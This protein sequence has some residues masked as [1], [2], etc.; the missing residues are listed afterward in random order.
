[1][2][3]VAKFFGF[4]GFGFC[5]KLNLVWIQ[6]ALMLLFYVVRVVIMA[7]VELSASAPQ[8]KEVDNN[9]CQQDVVLNA[10]RVC[11]GSASCL[12]KMPFCCLEE[13]GYVLRPRDRIFQIPPYDCFQLL[14]ILSSHPG[15]KVCVNLQ[16]LNY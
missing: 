11:A 10:E 1:M 8:S 5:N 13:H 2:V 15:G 4:F 7:A 14:A 3:D 9:I 12:C 16:W 6:V